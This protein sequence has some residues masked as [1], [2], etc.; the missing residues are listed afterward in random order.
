MLLD[1]CYMILPDAIEEMQRLLYSD[2]TI[3]AVM[4]KVIQNGSETA[5]SY[6]EAISRIQAGQIAAGMNLQKLELTAGCVLL[7]YAML[8]EVGA[9]DEKIAL[10][11]NVMWDYCV[12][13][14]SFSTGCLKA[15]VR[16]SIRLRK[17]EPRTK[18]RNGQC[19]TGRF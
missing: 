14:S 6:T 16:S 13:G 8:E 5:P 17:R 1:P 12:R 7:K 9:F 2:S 3:G 10:A 19:Q 15:A 11:E 18:T 4:P